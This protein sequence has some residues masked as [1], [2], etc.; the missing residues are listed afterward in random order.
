MYMSLMHQLVRRQRK[1]CHASLA[2]IAKH[3]LLQ[4]SQN[5]C[6]CSHE[7][8]HL[9]SAG[10]LELLLQ[11]LGSFSQSKEG[12]CLGRKQHHAQPRILRTSNRPVLESPI[13]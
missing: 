9:Q 6:F 5:I 4:Q 1:E 10:V 8:E 2:A 11:L 12:L 7:E 3:L 13:V